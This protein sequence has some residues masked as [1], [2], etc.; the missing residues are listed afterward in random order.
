M[1][2]LAVIIP[3][4]GYGQRFKDAGYNDYKPFIKIKEKYMI[5]LALEPYPKNIKKYL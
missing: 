3:M 2:E 1:D 4:A 5:N